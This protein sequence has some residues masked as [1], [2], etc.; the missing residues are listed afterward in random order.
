[1]MDRKKAADLAYAEGYRLGATSRDTEVAEYKLE[2]AIRQAT[3]K[4]NARL[5]VE[6]DQLRAQ[7]NKLLEL[8]IHST[9]YRLGN[10]AYE[11]SIATT[12]EQSLAEYRN[13]VIEACA[14]LC[15][16]RSAY[17]NSASAEHFEAADCAAGLRAMKD[18][19]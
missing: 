19:P 2:R 5:I 11:A 8:V 14:K 12:T 3:E 10:P 7:T 15:D 6:R 13:E 9:D 18:Q 16:E 4:S 17:F 1:M